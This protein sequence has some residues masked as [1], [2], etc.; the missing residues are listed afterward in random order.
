MYVG[1]TRAKEKVYLLYTRERNI[2]GSLQV[3]SPSRFLDD[4][5]VHLMEDAPRE[6]SIFFSQKTKSVIQERRISQADYIDGD[7]V[8]HPVFGSGL[9][10]SSQ[11][12]I[13]TIAFSK[14]GLKKLS[15]SIAPLQKL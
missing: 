7:R 3:N 8:E 4:I 13:L 15:A 1:L 12:D 6:K 14:A 2:F 10:I 9:I 11:G 5:P